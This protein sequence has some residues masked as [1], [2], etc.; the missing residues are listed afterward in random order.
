MEEINSA[1]D[2]RKKQMEEI[3]MKER[4]SYEELV[5]EK[6][7][8]ALSGS[9]LKISKGVFSDL[10]L[11]DDIVAERRTL[12]REK[13][14]DIERNFTALSND[15]EKWKN[16]SIGESG[17]ASKRPREFNARDDLGQFKKQKI[18]R[19][20]ETTEPVAYRMSIIKPPNYM[21][22]EPNP[23]AISPP[24]ISI[25][26]PPQPTYEINHNKVAEVVV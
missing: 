22:P 11:I 26:P 16:S 5:N 1:Y 3:L 18:G 21:P 15:V 10:Q 12:D 7:T 2:L 8:E 13:Q 14:Q 9:V 19:A 20:V 4:Q 6:F 23:I 17:S 25:P 24:L